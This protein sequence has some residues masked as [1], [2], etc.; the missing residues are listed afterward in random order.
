MVS[1]SRY[2]HVP[3]WFSVDKALKTVKV[4]LVDLRKHSEL[5]VVLVLDDKYNLRGTL[6]LGALLKGMK[7]SKEPDK[8]QA[9]VFM[10]PAKSSVGPSDPVDK[11]ASLMIEEG[12]DLLPVVDDKARFVGLARMIDVFEELSDKF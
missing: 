8:S 1:I 7:T 6:T 10:T 4:S 9:S 2:P 5:P 11:A 12:V 3:L